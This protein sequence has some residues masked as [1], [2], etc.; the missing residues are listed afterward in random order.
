MTPYRKI[1]LCVTPQQGQVPRSIHGGQA[2][3]SRE[4]TGLSWT[5]PQEGLLSAYHS[6]A[7]GSSW[8]PEN[9]V[10]SPLTIG[11]I[12]ALISGV[13]EE[14]SREPTH[15]SCSVWRKNPW[16]SQLASG[17]HLGQP[18]PPYPK[19][20]GLPGPL[21]RPGAQLGLKVFI[22]SWSSGNEMDQPGSESL[23]TSLCPALSRA[24]AWRHLG[25][26][27]HC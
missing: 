14:C 11:P 12:P 2:D 21:L 4:P 5:L 1:S 17:G 10:P 7:A 27:P 15:S 8:R 3:H 22:Y 16:Q 9:L 25:S 24:L 13:R 20:R 6:G 23:E 26:G 18:S 19:L